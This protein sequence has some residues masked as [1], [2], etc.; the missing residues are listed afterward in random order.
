GCGVEGFGQQIGDASGFAL[1]SAQA[2]DEGCGGAL[3]A[4]GPLKKAGYPSDIDRVS[5]ALSRSIP[6][7]PPQERWLLIHSFS[8]TDPRCY[9]QVSTCRRRDGHP[10]NALC[11]RAGRHPAGARA[12]VFPEVSP[13]ILPTNKLAPI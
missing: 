8:G 9:T 5:H 4:E 3:Q 2:G 11:W 6:G 1:G 10:P 7:A 12:A 13:W